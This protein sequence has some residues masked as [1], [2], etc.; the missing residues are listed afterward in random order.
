MS[1]FLSSYNVAP[2][3]G[4]NNAG[5]G[6]NAGWYGSVACSSSN[7]TI[8]NVNVTAN[9]VILLTPKATAGGNTNPPTIT[10]STTGSFVVNWAGFPA[11]AFINYYILSS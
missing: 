11:S 6:A 1:A 5:S 7:T 8:S 2:V 10:S 9:S 3:A 4:D